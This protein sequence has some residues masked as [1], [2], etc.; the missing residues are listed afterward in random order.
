[1]RFIVGISSLLHFVA[2]AFCELIVG[3][4]S[5]LMNLALFFQAY[6]C[7]LTLSQCSLII[8]MVMLIVGIGL[9]LADL[10][11]GSEREDGDNS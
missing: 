5:A 8:Y 11:G 7:Y 9:E 1:M 6:S 3:P 4:V 2:F 10:F